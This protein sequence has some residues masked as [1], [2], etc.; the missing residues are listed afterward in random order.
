MMML[1]V[2][3]RQWSCATATRDI[4][5]FSVINVRQDISEIQ[6][7]PLAAAILASATETLILPIQMRATREQDNA[8][9]VCTTEAETTAVNV[10]M[11]TMSNQTLMAL[12]LPV[13]LADATNAEEILSSETRVTKRLASAHV[14]KRLKAE[15]AVPVE[16]TSSI[17]PMLLTME[18]AK[19]VD[20]IRKTQKT[21]QANNLAIW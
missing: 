14:L 2:R 6:W 15:L 11:D 8:S 19:R 12:T 16:T 17:L 9:N 20:A 4:R 1:A 13:F 18:A 7:S 3:D 10:L 21:F 5:D